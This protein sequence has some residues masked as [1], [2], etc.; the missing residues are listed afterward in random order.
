MGAANQEAKDRN[1]KD[2]KQAPPPPPRFST[3]PLPSS[4]SLDLLS[5]IYKDDRSDHEAQSQ[6]QSTFLA[7]KP[8]KA[9]TKR[10]RETKELQSY[11]M[12]KKT[13][14]LDKIRQEATVIAA[15]LSREETKY[16]TQVQPT[17]TQALSSI[18]SFVP[19]QEKDMTDA[20]IACQIY[21][22]QAVF[23]RKIDLRTR[24][25]LGRCARMFSIYPGGPTRVQAAEAR[26][27]AAGI[28]TSIDFDSFCRDLLGVSDMVVRAE[29]YFSLLCDEFPSLLDA[30]TRPENYKLFS[31]AQ[32]AHTSIEVCVFYYF[33]LCVCVLI[34]AYIRRIK[35]GKKNCR[36]RAMYLRVL[37][38]ILTLYRRQSGRD[39]YNQVSMI[40][41]QQLPHLRR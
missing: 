35:S 28:D 18:L 40:W 22:Q 2:E 16:D 31:W 26:R 14:V 9:R 34:M 41:S 11:Q 17:D 23:G 12:D 38:R 21:R 8:S 10:K 24:F 39:K 3:L 20:T 4:T 6:P 1:G 13:V 19:G 36:C 5:A 30:L 7:P 15:R 37:P 33:V 27:Q 29:I 32:F 25:A